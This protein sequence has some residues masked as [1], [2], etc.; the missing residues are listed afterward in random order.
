MASNITNREDA[1]NGRAATGLREHEGAG[2]SRST[3]FFTVPP[4]GEGLRLDL[5]LTPLIEECSRSRLQKM[6]HEGL[7]TVDGRSVKPGHSLRAGERVEVSLPS[8]PSAAEALVPLEIP[9]EVLFEDADIVA[10][11][12]PPGLVVHPGAG[13]HD[14]TLVQALLA[15][16]GRLASQGAPLRPGIVHRLDRDTSGAMVAA[17]SD[18]AYLA[19]IEAFQERRV[20]KEYLALAHG[21]FRERSGEIRTLLDR[22]PKDRK[23]MAVVEGKGREAVSRWKVEKDWDAVALLRL[24]IETGRTH[25]IRVHLRHLGHPV[26]GDEVYGADRRRVKALRSRPLRDLLLQV[27]RQML[28]AHRLQLPHP[29]TAE[30]LSFA[31]PLPEDFAGLLDDLNRMLT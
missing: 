13:E 18:R 23:K 8:D 10:V 7:V 28:H 5:F 2:T 20:H 4:D 27:P 1:I 6:I 31:A 21:P 17:K 25:Q 14:A 29:V 11:N 19:L 12:K 3:A 9:L 16:C 30:P 24:V 26:V 22:H 15:R